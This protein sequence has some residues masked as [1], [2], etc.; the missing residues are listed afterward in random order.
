MSSHPEEPALEP[1][2]AP[3]TPQMVIRKYCATEYVYAV[4]ASHILVAIML[5]TFIAT[6]VIYTY[7]L[8]DPDSLRQ[9]AALGAASS[10]V[11]FLARQNCRMIYHQAVKKARQEGHTV[12]GKA[13]Y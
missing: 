2:A 3:L 9:L 11:S 10:I 8:W 6:L 12:T 5:A 7:T 13:P 4:A 1:P